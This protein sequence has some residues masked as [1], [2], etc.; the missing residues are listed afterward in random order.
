MSTGHASG[1]AEQGKPKER[2]QLYHEEKAKGGLGLTIFGGSSS[3]ARDS[4]AEVFNQISVSDDTIIPYFRQFAERIHRHGTAIFCQLTHMGVRGRFDSGNWPILLSSSVTREPQNRSY[5][6]E[7]EGWDI[8]RVIQDYAD[9]ARRC[10]EGGLDGCE[11]NGGGPHLIAQFLSPAIN[12]RNDSYGGSL[13]NRMQFG[14]E[15]FQA[16]RKAVGPDFIVGFRLTGDDMQDDGLSQ[17]DSVSIARAFASSGL[18]DFLNVAGGNVHN[19]ASYAR[20]LPNMAFEAAPFLHLASAIRKKVDIPIFHATRI[21]DPV[22]ANRAVA[23]GHVDMIAMTRAHIADPHIVQKIIENRTDDIRP[24]VGASYCL[25]RPRGGGVVCILNPATGREG[26]IPHIL[27]KA[28]TRKRVI[29]VGAGPAGCEA[30]RVAAERGH[31]VVL[32][33]SSSEIGGQINI[34]ARATWRRDLN[35]IIGWY[36]HQLKK[37]GVE[38]RLHTR[39]KASTVVEENP[40]IVIVA[41]GGEPH[42]GGI[43]G[44]DIAITTWDILTGREQPASNVLIFDNHS[45]HQAPSCAEV[46]ART[47][48]AVELVTPDRAIG[49]EITTGNWPIHLRELYSLGVAMTSDSRV[50]ELSRD[51]NRIAVT[52]QN[53]YTDATAIRYVDQVVVENGTIPCAEIYFDLLPLSRNGGEIDSDA[54]LEG[55]WNQIIRNDNGDFQLFRVGDALVGRNI[56]AAIYDSIRLCKNL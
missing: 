49:M 2:Y 14:L 37:L 25:G 1:Y 56:H 52:L 42:S 41:T 3:V 48:A 45:D 47:G 8:H 17:E 35:G 38:I 44:G 19:D 23:E 21:L 10:L 29:V 31:E 33:E 9:A 53:E 36:E 7:M 11:I 28:E 22:T 34:A 46:A 20:S 50:T 40:D 39:A 43:V 51:G 26:T 15:V 16:V 12:K 5:A 55:N 27:P 4:P 54:I 6:K 18:I 32:F 30:A 13:E 24:C